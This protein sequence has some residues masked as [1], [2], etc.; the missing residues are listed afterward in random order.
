MDV[1][2]SDLRF[3]YVEILESFGRDLF[4]IDGDALLAYVLEEF[5]TDLAL[6]SYQL[7]PIVF[8]F[9]QVL[10]RLIKLGA[11]FRVFFFGLYQHFGW[12]GTEWC[13]G[14]WCGAA[15]PRLGLGLLWAAPAVATAVA[16]KTAV[17]GL[18]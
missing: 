1:W 16:R 3:T 11:Q 12:T 4:F 17:V 10:E 8:R 18:R 9:E 15:L 6:P 5:H 7:L 13:G 2:C 14:G